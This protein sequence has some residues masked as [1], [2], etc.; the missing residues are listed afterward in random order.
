MIGCSDRKVTDMVVFF[1]SSNLF[2]CT[3]IVWFPSAI[4]VVAELAS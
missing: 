3:I 4:N 1:G 2:R